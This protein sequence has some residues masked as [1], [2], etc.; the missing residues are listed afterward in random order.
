MG[1]QTRNLGLAFWLLSHATSSA[2]WDLQ[3]PSCSPSGGLDS[4]CCF[5]TTSDGAFLCAGNSKGEVSV[6]ETATGERVAHTSA[7]KVPCPMPL[8]DCLC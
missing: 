3:V 8:L 5:G 6:Y 7:V 1:S 2:T 4:R